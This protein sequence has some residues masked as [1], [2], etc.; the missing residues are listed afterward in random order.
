[1][2]RIKASVSAIK[3]FGGDIKEETVVSKVLR[4]ILLIYAIRV[5]TI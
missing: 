4:N 1:M 2:E 3:E 5:S